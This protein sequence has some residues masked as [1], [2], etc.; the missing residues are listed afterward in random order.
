MRQQQPLQQ[1]Q[2]Q[3]QPN[4]GHPQ[5]RRAFEHGMAALQGEVSSVGAHMSIDSSVRLMYTR[6]IDAM[7]QELNQCVSDQRLNWQQAAEEAHRLR[8]TIME[9]ARGR[10]TPVGRSFA[11]N[12]KSEGVSLSTILDKKAAHRFQLP[13]ERLSTEQRNLVFADV[14]K[15]AGKSNPQVTSRMQSFSYAGRSLMFLSMATSVYNIAQAEDRLGAS[16]RE[17]AI[18]GAGVGGGLAGGAMT[19]AAFAAGP[20]AVSMGAFVG[21]AMAAY[22][23]SS[24]FAPHVVMH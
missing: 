17:A 22:A 10:S 21:G 6:R 8:N 19:A 9:W 1:Q 23:A 24:Y 18:Q 12:L 5:D 14:V 13:F 20:A 2:K 3:P 15:S 11:Q 7:A 4:P 16:A